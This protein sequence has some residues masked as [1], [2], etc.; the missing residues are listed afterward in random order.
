MLGCVGHPG[1]C[2]GKFT[3]EVGD[4]HMTAGC[5]GLERF[6]QPDRQLRADFVARPLPRAA[7]LFTFHAGDYSVSPRQINPTR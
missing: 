5:F 3:H 1:G 2:R 4:R 6:S 7:C